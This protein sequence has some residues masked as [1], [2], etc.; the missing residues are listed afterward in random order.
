MRTQFSSFSSLLLTVAFLACAPSASLGQTDRPAV[1]VMLQNDAGAPAG[2]VDHARVEATRLFA[3][4]GVELRWL[5]HVPPSGGRFRTISVTNWE[6]SDQKIATSVLGYTQTAEGKR[7]IRAYVFW[8]R[9]ERASQTF[10]ASLDKVLAIAMAHELGHMLLPAGRHAKDG[11]MR[12]PWDANHFRS[13]SA[14]LLLFCDDSANRIRRQAD[15]EHAAI[16]ASRGP[17]Q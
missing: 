9:V 2:V 15:V 16:N 11:L 12:A 8:R 14:G 1:A 5:D 17:T 6:P 7:G 3:L 13:A 4:I 10:T